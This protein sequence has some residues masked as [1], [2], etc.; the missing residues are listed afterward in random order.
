MTNDEQFTQ[1]DDLSNE[2]LISQ[3]FLFFCGFG[4]DSFESSVDLTRNVKAREK[5]TEETEEDIPVLCNDLRSV[6][7]SQSS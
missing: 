2:V 1:L 4:D 6:E 7:I 3:Q 5:I